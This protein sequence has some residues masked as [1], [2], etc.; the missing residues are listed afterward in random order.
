V[1]SLAV[2]LAQF[3]PDWARIAAVA[4]IVLFGQ[5]LEGNVLSPNLVG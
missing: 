3:V 5:F 4:G 2:A 1:L